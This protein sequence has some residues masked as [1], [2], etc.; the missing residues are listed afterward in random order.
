MAESSKHSEFLAK[1]TADIV[2]AYV[3]NTTLAEANL[4]GLIKEIYS[5]LNE[6]GDPSPALG[7]VPIPAVSIQSSITPDYLICLEDGKKLKMLKRH[8]RSFYG[9]TPDEYRQ[10][11]GLPHDY[12]MVAPDYAATRSRLAFE[13][14]LGQIRAIKKRYSRGTVTTT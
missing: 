12:P 6:L 11:W 14:G 7:D 10:K 1:L 5:T 9:M 3:S 8:L 13:M 2:G 4:A